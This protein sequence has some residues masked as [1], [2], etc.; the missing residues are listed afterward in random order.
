[1]GFVQPTVLDEPPQYF[2]RVQVRAV[3][4]QKKQVHILVF[5]LRLSIIDDL[6]TVDRAIVEDNNNGFGVG[7]LHKISK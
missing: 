4:R 1:M 5:P 7:L 3:G 2:D 6:A